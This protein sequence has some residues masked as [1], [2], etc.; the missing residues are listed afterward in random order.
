MNEGRDSREIGFYGNI[1][2][3]CLIYSRVSGRYLLLKRSEYIREG[4]KWGVIGGAIEDGEDIECGIKREIG[5]EIGYSGEIEL[6]FLWCY[7]SGCGFRYSNYIGYVDREIGVELNWE[8]DEYGWYKLE[9]F[10]DD[11]HF[12]LEALL[13]HI[14]VM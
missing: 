14:G 10:P 12:G 1:G 7:E 4:G 2:G 6:K 3:G 11:L 13:E 9:E 8:S 5:E